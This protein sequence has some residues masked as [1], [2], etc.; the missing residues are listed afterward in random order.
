MSAFYLFIGLKHL[1]CMAL[2]CSL[3]SYV[4]SLKSG[5]FRFAGLHPISYFHG[6]FLLV[7]VNCKI[8]PAYLSQTQKHLGIFVIQCGIFILRKKSAVDSK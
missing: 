5:L 1:L 6:S 4:D 3:V 8:P 7:I 2:L